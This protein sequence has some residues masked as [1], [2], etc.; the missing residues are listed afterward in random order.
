LP[1]AIIAATALTLKAE[2]LT[3]DLKIANIADLSVK[4]PLLK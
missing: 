4:V 3:N 1:D 2:L